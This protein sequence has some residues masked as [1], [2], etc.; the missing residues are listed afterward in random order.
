[1]GGAVKS[2]A[3]LR[4]ASLAQPC[5]LWGAA[6][7][8]LPP[9]MR[10]QPSPRGKR[11]LGPSLAL[12]PCCLAP[13]SHTA[14]RRPSPQPPLGPAQTPS[15]C[16]A[17][18]RGPG[19]FGRAPLRHF[20]A[21]FFPQ[22]GLRAGCGPRPPA[23]AR[24]APQ[25]PKPSRQEPL[26]FNPAVAAW[27]GAARIIAGQASLPFGL[28]ACLPCS[29]CARLPLEPPRPLVLGQAPLRG[30]LR[31][32][33]G[34]LVLRSA[35]PFGFFLSFSWC[36]CAALWV[37]PCFPP[38]PCRPRW[39]LSGS[40]G[41]VAGLRPPA[42]GW[43]PLGAFRPAALPPSILAGAVKASG[44]PALTAPANKWARVACRSVLRQKMA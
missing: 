3:L 41:L 25:Q 1:M 36:C 19:L 32:P 9:L 24:A 8:R 6:A 12:A 34:R 22:P 7:P 10:G 38:R 26:A 33:A 42:V 4:S 35:P 31:R 27:L 28:R 37:L 29:L 11:W 5:S 17:A 16:S 21:G 44:A 23:P 2:L 43:A 40:A 20:P 15:V 39:G 18:G 13:L 14:A 30:A